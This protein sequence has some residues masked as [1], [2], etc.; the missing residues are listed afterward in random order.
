MTFDPNTYA[1]LAAIDPN[2]AA[3]Y[4]A[5]TQQPQAPSVS[6]PPLPQPQFQQPQYQAQPQ[7]YSNPAAVTPPPVLARGTLEDFYSQPTGGSAP[8]VTS[9]FFG[10][11]PQG[12]WLQL[13]VDADA[14]NADVRQ[15]T[16]P[17]GKPQTFRDG[18]PKFALVVKVHVTGSSDGTHVT[19]FPDGEASL[20]VKGV[21][22]DEL[23]RAMTAGG[24]PSGYPKGGAVIVMQSVG[25][26]PA[27]TPGFSATKLYSLQYAGP[28]RDLQ[29]IAQAANPVNPTTLTPSAT[30]PAP[31]PA[32]ATPGVPATGTVTPPAPVLTAPLVQGT[33]ALPAAALTPPPAAPTSAPTLDADK[34]ALLARLQ[35][36]GA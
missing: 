18:R 24:D 26:K 25:E 13:T 23:R 5:F 28:Q 16:T 35:G 29:A 15:Q 32:P 7:G 30:A 20:W 1:Q 11:R 34:A 14:T 22:A 12:A 9:K 17:D 33:T 36:L 2:A 6:A 21:L 10:K 8:S 19:E 31:S 4:L 3:S 27:R